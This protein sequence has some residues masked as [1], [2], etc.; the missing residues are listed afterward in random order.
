[1]KKQ[2]DLQLLEV[3]VSF[4]MKRLNSKNINRLWPEQLPL[5]SYNS[6]NSQDTLLHSNLQCRM[7]TNELRGPCSLLLVLCTMNNSLHH[8]RGGSALLR[9]EVENAVQ[10]LCTMTQSESTSMGF[11]MAPENAP[12]R[13]V[14]VVVVWAGPSSYCSPGWPKTSHHLTL[15]SPEFTTILSRPLHCQQRH[16]QTHLIL[17]NSQ[18]V[19]YS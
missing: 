2:K 12:H 7:I 6:H 13:F 18:Q 4:S 11:K 16:A 15:S 5:L 3:M 8:R 14:V 19:F 9:T 10:L 1:M 17:T